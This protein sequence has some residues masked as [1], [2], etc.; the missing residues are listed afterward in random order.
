MKG[1]ARPGSLCLDNEASVVFVIMLADDCSAERAGGGNDVSYARTVVA[2][3]AG[4]GK[5]GGGEGCA[6]TH[7]GMAVT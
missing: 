2:A 5:G 3:V 4:V 1:L 7:E 6:A